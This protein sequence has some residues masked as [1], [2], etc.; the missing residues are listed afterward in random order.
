MKSTTWIGFDFGTKH[1]GI[2][3]GE[4]ITAHATPLTTLTV[5]QNQIPWEQLDEIIQTWQP[6]ACVVGLPTDTEGKDLSITPR[7]KHFAKA[8]HK[9]YQLDLYLEN[10]HLSTKEAKSLLHDRYGVIEKGAVDEMAA[11]VILQSFL[12]RGDAIEPW[13]QNN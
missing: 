10:E 6:A 1:I 3:T 11:C 9:R 8:L 2:A 7:V 4:T 13:L 5:K 12:Q